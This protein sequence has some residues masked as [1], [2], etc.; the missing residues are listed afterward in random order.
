[1]I[2]SL[3]P[4]L[5]LSASDL[6]QLAAYGADPGPL[7][8]DYAPGELLV[9][10]VAGQQPQAV[11][12][13]AG[14]ATTQI[15][16]VLGT[17]TLT[18]SFR[19]K[20]SPQ[21]K[22]ALTN[23]DD[24]FV[25]RLARGMMRD[26]ERALSEIYQVKLEPGVDVQA[27]IRQLEKLSSVVFAEPNYAIKVDMVPNDPYWSSSDSWDQGYDDLWGL[28]QLDCQTAWNT[29]QGGGVLVAVIDSG[30]DYTHPDLAG[31]MWLNTGEIPGDGIDNDGNGPIDDLYGWDFSDNDSD[32]MDTYGHGTHCAGTIAAVG[33][34]NLGVIGVA[35]QAKIMPVRVIGGSVS[36]VTAAIAGVRYAADSGA[37]VISCSWH[38]GYSQALADV[39]AYA[40]ND[41][42]VVSVVSAGNDNSETSACCPANLG[43]VIT[44]AA[45]TPTGMKAGFSNYGLGV[46]IMA[47]GGGDAS[48]PVNI[49][50]TISNTC[51]I[52]HGHQDMR[53]GDGYCRLSGTSMACPHVAGIAAL[54][55]GAYPTATPSEVRARIMAGAEYARTLP[56]P[57]Q[58]GIYE[59]N[60]DYPFLL[61]AGLADAYGALAVSAT[62]FMQ[63]EGCTAM[64]YPG[65]AGTLQIK[66]RNAWSNAT[67]VTATFTTSD[68]RITVT[69]GTASLGNTASGSTGSNVADPFE[70]N[71]SSSMEFGDTFECT[72]TLSGD[73][74]YQQVMSF[75]LTASWFVNR[76]QIEGRYL[77]LDTSI[78]MSVT[79]QDY[80]NDGK[81]EI[82]T[83][84][85][86]AEHSFELFQRDQEGTWVDIAPEIG[87][88]GVN[89]WDAVFAD[90]DG[91]GD[92][93]LLLPASVREGALFTK[94]YSNDGD[95][96][97]TDVSTTSGLGYVDLIAGTVIDY[98]QDGDLDVFKGGSIGVWMDLEHTI[99]APRTAGLFRNNGNMTFTA[100]PEGE[101]GFGGTWDN[102]ASSVAF[103]YDLDGDPDLL[104]TQK[105]FY[106]A[107]GSKLMRNNADGTFTDVTSAAGLVA[108]SLNAAVGD[109]DNDGDLDVLT[110]LA[111][112]GQSRLFLYNNDG[113]GLFSDGTEGAGLPLQVAQPYYW[114][115]SFFDY[116]NDAD[117]DI[118]YSSGGGV[119]RV[120]ANDG[121]GTFTDVSAF[122][123]PS[124]T[125]PGTGAVGIG[126]YDNNGSLDLVCTSSLYVGSGCI[127]ENKIALENNW[128]KI[129]PTGVTSSNT[130]GYGAKIY[131]TT[132]STT[133]MREI[134]HDAVQ[135]DIVHFGL[136]QNE[137][138]DEVRI[139]WPDGT[140]QVLTDVDANQTLSVV[141]QPAVTIPTVTGVARNVTGGYS[142]EMQ[143]LRFAFSKSVRGSLEVN[144]L[145]LENLTSGYAVNVASLGSENLTYDALN[146]T[147]TWNLQ[148]LNLQP[149]YYKATLLASGINDGYGHRLDGNADGIGGDNWVSAAYPNQDL[150]VTIGGD[151]NL[152]G[153]VDVGDLGILSFNYNQSGKT[154]A[155]ADFDH[156]GWV[157]AADEAILTPAFGTTL[158]GSVAISGDYMV[159]A[160]LTYTL[161]MAMHGAAGGS[162]EATSWEVNWGDGNV[163]TITYTGTSRQATHVY[164]ADPQ[165]F[166][167]TISVRATVQD[168]LDDYQTIACLKEIIV[169]K[170]YNGTLATATSVSSLPTQISTGLS[171]DSYHPMTNHDVDLY[172]L[173]AAAGQYYSFHT[174]RD[175][176]L[177]VFDSSGTELASA[178]GRNLQFRPTTAG[179]YYVGISGIGNNGYDPVDASDVVN[180]TNIGT[181]KL[182]ISCLNNRLA[183]AKSLGA[184]STTSTQAP[185]TLGT[186]VDYYNNTVNTGLNDLDVYSFTAEQGQTIEYFAGGN[187]SMALYSS[188]GSLIL[189]TTGCEQWDVPTT[190][191]YY[192]VIYGGYSA[193]TFNPFTGLDAPYAQQQLSYTLSLS[194]YEE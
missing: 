66:V 9:R 71:V 122:V 49:L 154:W 192:I 180:G 43:S 116:D 37:D 35:P 128:L 40:R 31:N 3:E 36:F 13:R 74:G 148:N 15:S 173:S 14:L 165:E 18:A 175:V 44:V 121:D 139:V 190:G 61:G 130:N 76:S 88:S 151:A 181:Y 4:K 98:D 55:L 112:P 34:N 189:Y 110:Y 58:E 63:T 81:V 1:M 141:E 127:L 168:G 12:A 153:L 75:C 57:D 69:D 6:G 86:I 17:D 129:K 125:F 100:M 105:G 138:A 2:E 145:L 183:D 167:A 155:Q 72:V 93:D 30:V 23:L 38:M 120:W 11:L 64:V 143:T 107:V 79:L 156:D 170:D 186:D 162:L 24:K 20:L 27:A 65:E 191:T 108:K 161:S 28:K 136:G 68:A 166:L 182:Q 50:S 106:S 21:Q 119:N 140:V 101:S 169:C 164:T 33:N 126:D 177:R 123:F 142:D 118:M 150:L 85:T 95:G 147:A 146:N 149:G 70:F 160:G 59:L 194:L 104:T 56:N 134:T 99:P 19:S 89:I 25:L 135:R 133:Q 53:V 7:P 22:D 132:G 152:D 78:P 115:T 32:P 158:H 171:Y 131:V 97:F 102:C 87:V 67:N 174:T 84:S 113:T 103:D 94:L 77:P 179:T 90:F 137:Q 83:A 39:F 111:S 47:P 172:S 54:V 124:G 117:L 91:D 5:L 178:T 51:S 193:P 60:P 157:N 45:N 188:A 41:K 109:Y 26:A 144:D 185:G 48:D 52:L 187:A 176:E 10:F 8:Q 42:G 159:R 96:T 80:N 62:P 92:N 184:L 46:D 16:T 163:D 82:A 29:T 73:N 114:G